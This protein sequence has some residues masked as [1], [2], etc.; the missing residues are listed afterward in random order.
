MSKCIYRIQTIRHMAWMSHCMLPCMQA[1]LGAGIMGVGRIP[2]LRDGAPC[3]SATPLCI[4]SDYWNRRPV[5]VCM[6]VCVLC[7]GVVA[8]QVE[9]EFGVWHVWVPTKELGCTGGTADA[10]IVRITASELEAGGSSSAPY[11][12]VLCSAL[13]PLPPCTRMQC[14]HHRPWA[15]AVMRTSDTRRGISGGGLTHHAACGRWRMTRCTWL[16]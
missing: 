4:E 11:L 16:S 2:I 7:A 15:D 14:L 5:I 10:L 1:L 3:G 12:K 8:Y 13:S 6:T 9:Q